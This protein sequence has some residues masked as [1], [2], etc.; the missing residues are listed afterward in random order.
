MAK[1]EVRPVARKSRQPA[2]NEYRP[3]GKFGRDM[4]I[5]FIN[6]P[7]SIIQYLANT[8]PYPRTVMDHE[9]KRPGLIVLN[10]KAVKYE[11]P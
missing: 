10:G 5:L 11:G 1:A 2:N 7:R 9:I 8:A 3:K 6:G 4:K